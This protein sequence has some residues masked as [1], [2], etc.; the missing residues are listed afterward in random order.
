[1]KSDSSSS[2]GKCF[3]RRST[4]TGDDAQVYVWMMLM[5]ASMVAAVY[6]YATVQRRRDDRFTKKCY[7]VNQERENADCSSRKENKSCL[8]S[9]SAMIAMQNCLC[10][11]MA[12]GHCS[13]RWFGSG[14][15]SSRWSRRKSAELPI[16][17]RSGVR[18]S[19]KGKSTFEGRRYHRDRNRFYGGG[20]SKWSQRAYL[21]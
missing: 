20:E 14:D 2:R 11:V 17:K 13:G 15:S 12:V 9:N 21:K 5:L 7:I 10:S 8:T 6:I 16:M 4:E 18:I 1:M 3:Q 19:T